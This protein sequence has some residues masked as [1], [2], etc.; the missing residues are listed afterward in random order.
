M[1]ERFLLKDN[2]NDTCISLS[3][4]D[5]FT[6]SPGDRRWTPQPRATCWLT[7][8]TISERVP[9]SI[10]TSFS[11]SITGRGLVCSKSHMKVMIRHTTWPS[12]HLAGLY[13][14]CEIS[15]AGQTSGLIT[16]TANCKCVGSD[17]EYLI[18]NIRNKHDDWKL[19]EIHVK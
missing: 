7:G 11:V 16:C 8:L 6:F 13:K 19:C 17:C 3:Q 9:Q 1:Q 14:V 2:N 4:T 15:E 18:I 10:K 5:M 12:C